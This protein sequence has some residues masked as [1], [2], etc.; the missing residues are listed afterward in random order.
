MLTPTLLLSAYAQGIFPM[1]ETAESA[2]LF[3]VNPPERCIL[4]LKTFHIPTRLART[5][6][7]GKYRMTINQ[8]FEKVMQAC[9]VTTHARK[10]T[11]IN[12]EIIEAYTA[13]HV[14]G[15]AHSV[16]AWTH[17]NKLAGGLYGVSLGRAFFGESMFSVQRDA[18]KVAL[19]HLA[20]R[21]VENGFTLLD[22]QF[23]ND[24]L[25]QFGAVTIPRDDYLRFLALALDGSAS[26]TAGS[27]ARGGVTGFL[28]SR[29][30]TS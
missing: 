6:R 17:D 21:L 4:P 11:W 12:A 13:L 28:Q 18:S 1:A 23:E 16:E 20:A 26:F 10:K 24:H 7:Q 30:Q 8:C 3:W 14:L 29:T 2:D 27:G 25:L 22:A 15:H 5:V 9:A 19:V